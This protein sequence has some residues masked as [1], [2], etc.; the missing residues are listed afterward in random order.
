MMITKFDLDGLLSPFDILKSGVCVK[1]CPDESGKTLVEGTDCLGNLQKACNTRTTYKSIDLFDFCIPASK[2]ALSEQE[3]LIYEKAKAEMKESPAGSLF[4]DLYNSS[5]AIYSCFGLALVWSLIFIYLLSW[6]AEQIAW[7]CVV[8]VQLG[9][10]GAAVGSYF[11][12]S[13]SGQD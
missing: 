10:I 8:L 12:W 4:T 9:L 3:W 6:F 5:N 7:C 13:R 11:L 2:D 1:T